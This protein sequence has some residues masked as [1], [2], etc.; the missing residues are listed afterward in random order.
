MR[1]SIRSIMLLTILVPMLLPSLA[2]SVWHTTLRVRDARAGLIARGE[3]DVRY[4][5]DAGSLALMVGD[6]ETL[7]RLAASNLSEL[8]C[9]KSIAAA[10]G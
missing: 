1:L 7:R 2:L 3:H 6:V 8:I 10:F 4:L 9:S 5:A